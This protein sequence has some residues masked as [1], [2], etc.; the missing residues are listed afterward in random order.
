[1]ENVHSF[2]ESWFLNPT[3]KKSGEIHPLLRSKHSKI[4]LKRNNSIKISQ[5]R[6]SSVILSVST[7]VSHRSRTTG[8]WQSTEILK[9]ESK[10]KWKGIKN[11]QEGKTPY[12]EPGTLGQSTTTQVIRS[13]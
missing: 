7:I 2:G 6:T 4:E 1:L 12:Y 8:I 9:L 10:K 11:I 3:H 13:A 5:G